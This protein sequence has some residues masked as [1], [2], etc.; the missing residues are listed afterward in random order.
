MNNKVNSRI[1]TLV[2]GFID[3]DE[4]IVNYAPSIPEDDPLFPLAQFLLDEWDGYEWD[5]G[6]ELYEREPEARSI[7][8]EIL[9][10]EFRMYL[11]R[12]ADF[13][14]E[15]GERLGLAPS[16][17]NLSYQ[18][19]FTNPK[20][21]LIE[22]VYAWLQD[23]EA[24][25]RLYDGNEPTISAAQ[26]GQDAYKVGEGLLYLFRYELLDPEEWEYIHSHL[27]TFVPAYH[28]YY[29]GVGAGNASADQLVRAIVGT[30]DDLD[31]DLLQIFAVC[32][33]SHAAT[34]LGTRGVPLAVPEA[35]GSFSAGNWAR[36]YI[37]ARGLL[38]NSLEQA[39][40]YATSATNWQLIAARGC[41]RQWSTRENPLSPVVYPV[42]EALAGKR[43][44]DI[45]ACRE[46]MELMTL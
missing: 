23:G 21:T 11:P 42:E 12:S 26:C 14:R 4:E 22:S 41:S 32:G 39:L 38:P 36:A 40:E 3:A 18:G 20:L 45:I 43:G 34:V 33:V 7:V 28:R 2:C 5:D 9:D 44:N 29:T 46:L 13:I 25:Y 17:Y 15:W 31:S 27:G 19:A 37:D 6:E 1:R 24:R 30:V 35:C 10:N 16:V 8:L